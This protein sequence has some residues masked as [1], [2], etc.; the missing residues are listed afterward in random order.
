MKKRC[1]VTCKCSG[2][3]CLSRLAVYE[4]G[5]RGLNSAVFVWLEAGIT[6]EVLVA[7]VKR[8]NCVGIIAK[9]GSYPLLW[10]NS[11]VQRPTRAAELF[12]VVISEHWD[13]IS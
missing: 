9:V 4:S 12:E 3:A 10:M 1:E 2:E 13:E 11:M 5:S 7:I 6:L 8:G